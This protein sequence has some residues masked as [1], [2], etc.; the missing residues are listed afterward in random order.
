MKISHVARY[1]FSLFI[2]TC[3]NAQTTNLP[4]ETRQGE[5]DEDERVGTHSLSRKQARLW[6]L[7][8]PI[9]PK[10]VG[11]WK[12]MV[13]YVPGMQTMQGER[14]SLQAKETGEGCGFSHR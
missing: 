8:V 6:V 5:S 3:E 2:C 14:I 10:E 11:K 4:E 12:F 1:S 7:S 13:K 9:M